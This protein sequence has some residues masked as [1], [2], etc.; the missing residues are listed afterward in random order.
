[1]DLALD[2][3]TGDLSISG[4]L[5]LVYDADELAQRLSIGLTINLNEF[6][7]HQNYGLPWLRGEDSTE[8]EDIQYFLGDSDTTLQYIISE[9]EDYILTIGQVTGVTSSYSYY[10]STR[11][12]EYT[13][14]ITGE[15][16][17]VIDFPPYLL[18][19]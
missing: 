7:T 18:Y 12:L 4:G 19:L 17:E 3:D 10:S 16:G 9:I 2:E 11:T 8:L 5:S 15:N 6:F 1:M 13:P 14:S